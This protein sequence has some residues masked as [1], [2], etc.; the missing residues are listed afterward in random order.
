MITIYFH[1]FIFSLTFA[2]KYGLL[3]M[4]GKSVMVAYN[5][6]LTAWYLP[7]FCHFFRKMWIFLQN[8]A[9]FGIKWPKIQWKAKLSR[10]FARYFLY[11]VC[12]MQNIWQHHLPWR[13]WY[14]WSLSS[15]DN[16][17]SSQ[18]DMII[19]S[20]FYMDEF[21]YSSTVEEHVLHTIRLGSSWLQ[22]YQL[23][24]C[25]SVLT[26]IWFRKNCL[27]AEP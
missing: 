6:C 15:W 8:F 25:K 17:S 23:K 7:T 16:K 1:L 13:R 18:R 2:P 14:P 26:L 20:S 22:Q 10:F 5:F 4:S 27:P 9:C 24:L 3:A 11:V 12:C 19:I 21:L